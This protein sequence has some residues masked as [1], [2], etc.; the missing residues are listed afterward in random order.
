DEAVEVLPETLARNLDA[1]SRFE[2]EARLVASL[3]HPHILALYDVGGEAGLRYAVMELLEGET[4]RAKLA[5]GPPPV[6]LVLE[7]ALQIVAGLGAAHE[8]GVV[9]R[10]LKPENLFVSR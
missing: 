3:S 7:W 5:S 4:L 8:K 1:L 2:R 6:R 10:D 9:H